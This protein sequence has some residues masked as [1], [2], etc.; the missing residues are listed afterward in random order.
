MATSLG[1]L[2]DSARRERFVG[3]RDEVASFDDALAGRTTRRVLFVHGQGGI[4]KSTLLAEFR[5]RA[6]AAGRAVVHVDGREV[7]PSPE[8][9]TTAVGQ[10]S[11]TTVLLIDGYEELRPID[12]W[13]RDEFVPGLSA[14][15][16]VVLAG[17]DQPSAPW[18]AD[19]G[20]RQ[21]VAVHHL[22]H[23]DAAESRALLE[24]A[25]VAPDVR[26][27]LA[28]L[29]QGHPLTIALLADLAATGTVPDALA[30]A[31]DLISALLES[32]LRDV[33]GDAHLTGLATCAIAWLTTEDLLGRMVGA[34]AP[35]V[36]RWL[37]GRPFV[38]R[39]PRGLFAHDL[40]RDV[41][42]AEFER[43]M[44]ERY[45]AHR[46]EIHAHTVTGLRATSGPDRQR[47]A[48]GLLFL[49]RNSP[50]ASAFTAL[51]AYGSAAVVPARAE[52]HVQ[53]CRIVERFEGSAELARAWLDEQP[54][55]LYVVR[56]PDR[57][58]AGFAHHLFCPSG[59]TLEE[60]DPV[61]R[62]VLDHVARHGPTRPGEL[63]NIVRHVGGANDYQRDPYAAL[64]APVSSVIEWL[65]RPLAWSFGITSDAEFWAPRFDHVAFARLVEVE[66][67]GRRHVAF[68]ID[69]RRLPVDTWLDL[70]RERGHSG[71]SG[72]APAALLRPP[73]LDRT[74][75]ATAVKALL[76]VL[77]RPDHVGA[78]PL[79]GSAL[80]STATGPT[81]EQ[82]RASIEAAVASLADRP[83]GDQLTAVL[84]RTY[85]RPAPTQEAAA[86][87]L[88]LPLSTYRRYLA[89]ALEQLTDLLWTVEIGDVR[90]PHRPDAR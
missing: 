10:R 68:G 52:D 59:S 54:E 88:D 9:L 49:Q 69:W 40:A 55:H 61:V 27:H 53:V 89:R 33:P 90:L 64:A 81:P 15:T 63:V 37:A 57:G 26:A 48:Q 70:M 6:R 51:R 4:G 42:D 65:T 73:P 72:P 82:L 39:G 18:R 66:A 22:D 24:R 2:L 80:A 74:R 71:E 44:P 67:G 38:T 86:Q 7:D 62:A 35:E 11:G 87:V 83:K 23:F 50:F 77:H 1:E 76:P 5:A 60:R 16:V 29:G 30:D 20:W 12:D 3:R 19:A 32:F 58:V 78:S 45:H 84:H 31:P 8:G 13:L 17:R 25:G 28:R 85:L 75:F 36:W 41:L 14:D 56:T 43:R 46:R 21:L 79:M 34:D 47:H